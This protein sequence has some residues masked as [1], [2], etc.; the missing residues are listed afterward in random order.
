[1]MTKE[2]VE[3]IVVCS[4]LFVIL[5]TAEIIKDIL[6]FKKTANQSFEN[7]PF[8]CA[9]TVLRR[10]GSRGASCLSGIYK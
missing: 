8:H 10:A 1:M 6:Q 9:R 3:S 7:A 4:I 2:N 5:L